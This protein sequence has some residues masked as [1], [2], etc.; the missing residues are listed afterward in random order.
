ME[1]KYY[2]AP[3]TRVAWIGFERNF[4][5]SPNP[6]NNEKPVDDGSEDF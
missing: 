5:F 2:Q 3:G 1:R 4:A 6:D